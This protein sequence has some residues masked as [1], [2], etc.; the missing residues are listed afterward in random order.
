MSI[1]EKIKAVRTARRMTQADVADDRITRN[2]ISAI[3][4]D[5]ALPSIDTLMHIATKLDVPVAYLL[6]EDFDLFTYRKNKMIEDIRR[7]FSEKRYTDCI[8]LIDKIDGTDD[9]IAYVLAYSNFEIGVIMARRGSFESAKKHLD[10][11]IK[12]ARNTVYNTRDMECRIPLYMSFLRNT[13]AP[14]LEFDIE[15]FYDA[16]VDTVDFEFFK[17]LCNDIEYQYKNPIFRKHIAA[18]IKI[19]ERKYYDAISILLEIE[20]QKSTFDYN[21]YVMYS[22]YS[23]LDSCYKQITDF[24]NAYKYS[25]KRISMLEGFNS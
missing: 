6:S 12:N 8:G 9:E 22:V 16:A 21:A 18:K 14:L 15:G 13:N 17:Y 7:A 24:E 4:S 11:A 10:I 19:R 25:G 23:D 2:M 5:K 20:R 3:E 1:G